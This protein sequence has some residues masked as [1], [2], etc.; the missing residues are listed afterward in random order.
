LG[1][2]AVTYEESAELNKRLSEIDADEKDYGYTAIAGKRL[3]YIG[4]YWRSVD[5]TVMG[6]YAFGVIPQGTADF[7][8]PPLQSRFIGFM[9]NNKWDYDYVFAD[10]EQWVA[11]VSLC[12]DVADNPCSDT[13]LALNDAVQA[14]GEKRHADTE[15][16]E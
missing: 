2:E 16:T 1:G 10:P 14:L 9:E 3:P 5:F 13:L 6:R 7:M 12:Q 11:I 4:W 15:A 8:C